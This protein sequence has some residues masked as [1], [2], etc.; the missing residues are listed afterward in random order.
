MKIVAAPYAA[1]FLFCCILIMGSLM[2]ID[3]S[4]G[5]IS[6]TYGQ[7]F[8]LMRP[9]QK[10][11]ICRN[12]HTFPPKPLFPSLYINSTERGAANCMPGPKKSNRPTNQW[13]GRPFQH[14]ERVSEGD[15]DG[16]ERGKTA[17][18]SFGSLPKRK[19]LRDC[20]MA[21]CLAGS[22]LTD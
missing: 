9:G 6:S 7:C 11:H 22:W 17:A 16:A 5:P 1:T 12:F 20:G 2:E 4:A 13:M 21:G 19:G 15:L 10:W 8:Q 14:R 3:G 18:A